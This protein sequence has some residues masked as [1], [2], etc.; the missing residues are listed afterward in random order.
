ML[1]RWAHF[2]APFQ[3]KMGPF[4]TAEHIWPSTYSPHSRDKL[5]GL[6]SPTATEWAF[7]PG[8]LGVQA[9]SEIGIRMGCVVA[10]EA[11][12]LPPA[13]RAALPGAKYR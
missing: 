7:S 4:L 12:C 3:L 8:S 2:S 1:P 11:K 10:D 5:H 9:V 13:L 6:K